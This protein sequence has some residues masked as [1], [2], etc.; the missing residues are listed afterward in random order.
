MGSL[1]VQQ[2]FYGD[3]QSIQLVH[4]FDGPYAPL[5]VP[6]HDRALVAFGA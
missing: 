1:V 2:T 4:L 3:I 5:T 6:S